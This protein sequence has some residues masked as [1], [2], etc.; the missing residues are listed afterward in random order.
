[1]NSEIN[2]KEF[3]EEALEIILKEKE[4]KEKLSSIKRQL[5]IKEEKQK[6]LI[7]T[8]EDLIKEKIKESERELSKTYDELLYQA[9]K[10]VRDAE[11]KKRKEKALKQKNKIDESIN[12]LVD[13]NDKI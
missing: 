7:K 13:D 11:D 1:M 9:D 10:K 12:P 4:E 5:T 6:S 3:F 2:T 8:K